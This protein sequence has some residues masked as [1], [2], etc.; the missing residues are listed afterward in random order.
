MG[1][2]FDLE[3]EVLVLTKPKESQSEQN[4]SALLRASELEVLGLV[5]N[6]KVI[7]VEG[8][9][10]VRFIERVAKALD[11]DAPLQE[12]TLHPLGGQDGKAVVRALNALKTP[13]LVVCD[14]D[15]RQAARASTETD[16]VEWDLPCIESYLF[17]WYYENNTA[18]LKE[19]FAINDMYLLDAFLRGFRA[20]N[21]VVKGET[22]AETRDTEMFQLWSTARNLVMSNE[23]FSKQDL[24]TIAQVIHGHTW[25]SLI[26]KS[27]PWLIDNFTTP[28][29]CSWSEVA[30]RSTLDRILAPRADRKD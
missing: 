11:M 16:I 23:T 15:F 14:R 5:S 22:T 25:V 7:L 6:R 26:K 20:Q 17:I 13:T 10:D 28:K 4:R 30:L 27:T 12:V 9:Q 29:A 3:R 21:K 19:L 18:E 24:V 1:S 2:V 8:Q